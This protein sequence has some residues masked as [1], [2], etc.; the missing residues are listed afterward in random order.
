[1]E[2]LKTIRQREKWRRE[3]KEE[4]VGHRFREIHRKA[5]KN[6]AKEAD[7]ERGHR[8]W[9]EITQDTEDKMK[10]ES[11]GIIANDGNDFYPGNGWG[12]GRIV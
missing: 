11:R 7:G 10:A 5:W 6:E 12:L 4:R 2:G 3:Q 8:E 1:M 9:R